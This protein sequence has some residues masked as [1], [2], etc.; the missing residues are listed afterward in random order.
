MCL[1]LLMGEALN[2][3]QFGRSLQRVFGGIWLPGLVSGYHNY[4]E[5]CYLKTEAI[6][7]S[8]LRHVLSCNA[9]VSL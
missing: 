4:V 5:I 7:S 9:T 8:K 6:G 1:G 3:S 2:H